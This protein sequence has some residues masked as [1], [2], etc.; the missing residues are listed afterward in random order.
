MTQESNESGSLLLEMRGI[1][2]DFSG[3]RALDQVDF[4]VRSGEVHA[5]VGENGAGKSTLIK[6]L[7]GALP[8][9]SGAIFLRG[10]PV[11]ISNPHKAQGLGI[12]IIYQ[13]LVL[14]PALN[15]ME[16][17]FLGREYRQRGLFLD[18]RR[19]LAKSR[20]LL[21]QLG[22]EI[23]A[24]LPVSRL[25]VAQRQMV[26]IARALMLNADLI[27]MDEPSAV[28]TT[29]ELERL[30]TIIRS[31]RARGK[32]VTYISHRLDEVFAL[33][34]R[35]TV[36]RDGHRIATEQIANLNRGSLIRMMV[37]R[38]IDATSHVNSRTTRK[39]RLEVR[40][41]R[42][43]GVHDVS[44][45]LH[46]GEILGIAGLVGAGRTELARFIFG[47]D[48][49]VGGEVVVD[50]QPVVVRSASD[51]V[52]RGIGLVPEDRKEQGL[53]PMMN[54]ADNILISNY[55]P[56]CQGGFVSSRK[57][58]KVSDGFIR[59][60]DIRTTG[61]RQKVQTLSGGNQQKVILARW[62]NTDVTIL[63]FDEPTR[64]ID[65]AAKQ[66]I[67]ELMR[68]LARSGKSFI[69]ISS[70]LPEV[71]AMS[72]R[73]LVMHE[74]KLTGELTAV[75]AT[76]EKILHLATGGKKDD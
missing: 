22:V 65:I 44:F 14:A 26:E 8:M 43:E 49:A 39:V 24:N 47:A 21:K 60:L 38:D 12:A 37:G 42:G 35:V 66:Q 50:G 30:F 56:A 69:M 57:T 19:M 1:T 15:A 10:Q 45:R 3:V 20:E 52:R 28:L 72:D 68:D 73:I 67:H 40:N 59:Q 6:I 29:A 55:Q 9:S 61:W 5:L 11:T 23:D 32:A 41:L 62:L 34:D 25:T 7:A 76:E 31:L 4:S 64:G 36:L 74:G 27:V 63:I 75:E 54:V 33:A 17:I 16:N 58:A 53:L 2:K 46:E 71:L 18:R 51:A 13:E 70:E 48:K